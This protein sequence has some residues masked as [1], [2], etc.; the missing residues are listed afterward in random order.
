MNVTVKLYSNLRISR[1]TESIVP[2]KEGA[3]IFDLI[4]KLAIDSKE[5]AFCLVNGNRVGLDHLPADGDVVVLF[6]LIGG[7]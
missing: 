3:K 6:P 7:G 1:F 2:L 5:I 4:N